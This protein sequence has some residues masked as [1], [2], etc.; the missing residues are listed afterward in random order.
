VQTRSN[1]E[2]ILILLCIVFVPGILIWN[3]ANPAKPNT[4]LRSQVPLQVA[5]T[6]R[7]EAVHKLRRLQS[8]RA[9]IEAH[10]KRLAY[11]STLTPEQLVP[12][13]SQDLLKISAKSG[14]HLREI[15][16]LRPRTLATANGTRV[17]LEV[18]FRAPFQPNVVRFL[19]YV[20]DPSGKMV[21]DKM[22][23]TSADP[24]SKTVDVSAQITVFTRSASATS[25]AEGGESNDVKDKNTKS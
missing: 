14:V 20:E 12:R 21:V 22:N 18:R 3:F 17:P 13:I 10:L 24:K 4:G 5:Q 19:Y 23:I 15:K 2:R 9:D 6:K 11:P 25:G 16:P 1:R 8:E 7:E